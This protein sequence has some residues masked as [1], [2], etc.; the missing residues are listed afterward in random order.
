MPSLKLEKYIWIFLCFLGVV[1]CSVEISTLGDFSIFIEASKDLSKNENIYSKTY[2]D[3]YHYYYSILFAIVLKLFN[4]VNI[5]VLKFIW[6]LL[7][8]LCFIH[9]LY[10]LNKYY[11]SKLNETKHKYLLLIFSFLFCLT[12][13][14]QNIHSSQITLFIL[15]CSIYS[16]KLIYQ[17]KTWLGALILAIGINIKILPIVLL[18][19]LVFNGK[20]KDVFYV[21]LF[22]FI[23]F[24]FPVFILGFDY[25]F[26]LIKSWWQLINPLSNK[27]VLDVEERSFHSLTTFLSVLLVENTHELYILPI[28]RNILNLDIN[29]LKIFIFLVRITLAISVLIFIKTP[30][31]KDKY[32]YFK[33]E[34]SYSFVLLL[35]PLIFPHQQHYAFVFCLPAAILICYY[36][37]NVKNKPLF[38]LLIIS[39]LCFNLKL[40]LGEFNDYYEHFK[41]IT[42]GALILMFLLYYVN[43]KVNKNRLFVL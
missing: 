21:V 43:S 27:H 2:F 13:L 31:F 22:Y 6:V 24:V 4:W 3:G 9:L 20:I 37:L 34:L 28:K 32:I 12:F 5:D 40:I 33:T 15:W 36:Y 41:L 30:Y 39:F 25:F 29:S 7:N 42:Y 26:E 17:N 8:Y 16:L 38:F 23:L 11:L 10:L 1:F 14:I 19:V 18:P 35:I